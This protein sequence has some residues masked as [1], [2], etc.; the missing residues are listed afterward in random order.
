MQNMH[1]KLDIL[2]TNNDKNKLK[3]IDTFRTISFT[4]VYV[5]IGITMQI[6]VIL[7]GGGKH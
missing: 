1:S 6:Y 2:V 4:G 5:Y 3:I 7:T